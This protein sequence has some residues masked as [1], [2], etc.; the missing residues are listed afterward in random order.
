MSCL[1]RL[2]AVAEEY[3]AMLSFRILVLSLASVLLSAH[4][5]IASV[6][7]PTRPTAPAILEACLDDLDRV[8]VQAD[9]KIQVQ[10]T[11]AQFYIERLAD[12]G[13]TQTKIQKVANSYKKSISNIA[14]SGQAQTNRIVG[15]GMLRMRSAPDYDRELQDE[16]FFERDVTIE[17]LRD[18]VEAA[19]DE[20]DA[21][22]AGTATTE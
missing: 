14:R 12:R 21:I 7:V 10:V 19:A 6:N 13:A 11:R 16:L 17:T 8:E 4:P 20:I 9:E 22:V 3:L 5:T 18:S 1:L 15:K 2:R